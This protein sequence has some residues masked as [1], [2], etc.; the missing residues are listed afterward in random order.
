M[1]LQ[2][3]RWADA[4]VRRRLGRLLL[5]A[6]LGL[7]APR[8]VTA[9][10]VTWNVAGSGNWDTVTG[11]WTGGS[12]T[13][14]LYANGDAAVFSNTAG[15][16]ITQVGTIAPSAVTVSA[17]SGTYT[18][19]GSGITGGT[20]TKSGGGTLV[21][22]NANAFSGITLSGGTIAVG[23]NG[24]LGTAAI[25]TTA[26]ATISSADATARTISNHVTLGQAITLGSAGT[27]DLLFTGNFS[28]VSART[29]TVNN[30]Q[31]EISGQVALPFTKAGAGTLILSNSNTIAGGITLNSGTLVL[32]KANN[33]SGNTTIS[34]GTLV[35]GHDS[36]VG[37]GQLGLR[38]TIHAL[39]AGARTINNA[40]SLD[41]NTTFGTS[42]TGN[43]LFTG[44]VNAGSTGKTF[45]VN[46]A[47]TEFSGNITK[48]GSAL[49]KSGA[50]TLI[51][52]GN[53]NS[54][55]NGMVINGGTL[56]LSG[57]NAYVGSTDVGGAGTLRIGSDAA[58]GA[59][60]LNLANG[61]TVT[62]LGMTARTIA[63]TVS[64]NGGTVNLGSATTGDLHFTGTLDTGG[65]S[66]TFNVQNAVTEFSG[67]IVGT[68]VRTKLGA[69]TMIFSGSV[70]AG[71]VQVDEGTLVLTAA[72]LHSQSIVNGGVLRVT[73]VQGLGTGMITLNGGVLQLLNNGSGNGG[74]INYGTNNIST[75]TGNTTT[76]HVGNN[77]ANTKN[78]ISLNP[79]GQYNLGNSTLN[80]TGA[81]GYSLE[82]TSLR[83]GAGQSGTAILNPTT[84]NLILGT[85]ANINVSHTL[86]FGGTS[87]GNRVTGTI[88]NGV[89]TL[90]VLKTGSSRWTFEG[91]N[92]YTGTT[93]VN[94]GTLVYNG[95]H[96]GN[97]AFTIG[98]SS[99]GT[100]IFN[101]NHTGTGAFTVNNQGTLIFNGAK[102][103]SG[104]ITVANGGTLGGR[105]SIRG[106]TTIQG[107]GTLSPGASPGTITF[108]NNLTLA[109][110]AIVAFESGDLVVVDGALSLPSNWVLDLTTSQANWTYD[111]NRWTVIFDYGDVAPT[112]AAGWDS[113][114]NLFLPDLPFDPSLV[115]LQNRNGQIVLMGM[116]AVPEPSTWALASVGLIGALFVA[117]R[118]RKKTPSPAV[119]A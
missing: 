116:Y 107:G 85:V 104:A 97:G 96:A 64:H 18:F 117:R 46:N 105:G 39:D 40:I 81:N 88:S 100:L 101:G 106:N 30:T 92:T 78:V 59:S 119:C 79:S 87:S 41:A 61:S 60:T 57:N 108:H 110:N 15:G 115:S 45:T 65:N 63:N 99:G 93:T 84:A 19:T 76:I 3:A 70:A 113:L 91:D 33:Y 48:T 24:A 83:A 51:L 58:L 38:G 20:L 67:P 5:L 72:N 23:A 89:G 94:A 36:A 31:T 28:S 10:T 52:S 25:T 7:F 114:S 77:G 29:I 75:N 98:S 53:L 4:D 42:T 26:A 35:V 17:A 112:L 69:G 13:A 27:G 6:A 16:T 90:T 55:I 44:A 68:N 34:A 86:Q 73:D 103:G 95:S 49:G 54:G 11:N 66:K 1:R 2:V 22:N 82:I 37:T 9:A 56:V 14:N 80:V 71:H 74:V 21:L 8:L 62:A 102:T 118:R 43:L 12:P 47:V 109:S 50:G 32:T 111:P